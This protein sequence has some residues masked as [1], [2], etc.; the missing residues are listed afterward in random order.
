[1][2][3]TTDHGNEDLVMIASLLRIPPEIVLDVESQDRVNL[4]KAADLMLTARIV[5]KIGIMSSKDVS[6]QLEIR[7]LKAR[8]KELE[9]E[10]SDMGWRLNPDRMGS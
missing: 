2:F 6:S 7:K 8:N 3:K 9:K 10:R 5:E 1:M 4:K